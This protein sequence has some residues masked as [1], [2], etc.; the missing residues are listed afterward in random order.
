[1]GNVSRVRGGINRCKGL[2]LGRLCSGRSVRVLRFLG[3]GGSSRG[4]DEVIGILLVLGFNVEDRPDRL[5]SRRP[6]GRY[7]DAVERLAGVNTEGS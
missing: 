5:Q 1:M 2:I 6:R 3:G 4:L 7:A